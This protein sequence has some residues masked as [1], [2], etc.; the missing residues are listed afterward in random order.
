[1]VSLTTALL[2]L[3]PLEAAD[4]ITLYRIY[5]TEGVLRYFPNPNPPPLEKVERFILVCISNSLHHLDP[6]VV[7]RL[8]GELLVAEMFR[9]RQTETQMTHVELHHW[10]AAVDTV[11]GVDHRETYRR[12]E[13]VEMVARLG[14]SAT[15]MVELSDLCD[16]PK[17]SELLSQLNPVIDCYIQRTEGHP[18]LQARGEQLRTRVREIGFHSAT[19]LVIL[20]RK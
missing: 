9:D 16:D 5:Q 8:G 14:L 18:D 2:T 17:S 4:A 20:A 11:C 1:M 12:A 15:R 3:R 19:T 7:L 6:E 10:W 13:L